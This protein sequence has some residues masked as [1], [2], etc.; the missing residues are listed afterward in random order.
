MNTNTTKPI[1]HIQVVENT[2]PKTKFS[3][4]NKISPPNINPMFPRC[5]FLSGIRN[6]KNIHKNCSPKIPKAVPLN[7]TD[8][9]LTPK[10]NPSNPSADKVR[11][12]L[13]PNPQLLNMLIF[14]RVVELL[15]I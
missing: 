10:P 3:I 7:P 4:P 5:A 2:S 13:V 8:D 11:I 9:T 12:I 1:I 6:P 14:I 15:L